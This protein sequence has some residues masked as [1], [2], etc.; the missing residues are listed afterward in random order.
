MS[1]PSPPRLD[2][3]NA[4]AQADPSPPTPPRSGSHVGE[5]ETS[6]PADSDDRRLAKEL[7]QAQRKA[8]AAGAVDALA[9]FPQYAWPERTSAERRMFAEFDDKVNELVAQREDRLGE[10]R[11]E[12]DDEEEEIVE[13][14]AEVD[15]EPV[16]TVVA[17]QG[18]G[19]MSRSAAMAEALEASIEELDRSR[20]EAEAA[21]EARTRS[22]TSS[23]AN[24]PS[25]QSHKRSSEESASR[26]LLALASKSAKKRKLVNGAESGTNQVPGNVAL[27]A[28]AVPVETP[29]TKLKKQLKAAAAK[30]KLNFAQIRS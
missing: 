2:P 21:V 5:L 17:S 22:R 28:A 4:P 25:A 30:H 14:S 16:A 26:E 29:Q 6:V 10:G 1:Q 13:E 18:R 3:L 15:A 12:E 19:R 9:E 20:V 27:Q 23:P 11:A 24:Q 8:A 7:R